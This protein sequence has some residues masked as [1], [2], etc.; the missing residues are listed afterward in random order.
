MNYKLKYVLF[1]MLIFSVSTLFLAKGLTFAICIG[2]GNFTNLNICVSVGLTEV[3]QFFITIWLLFWSTQCACSFAAKNTD[4]PEYHEMKKMLIIYYIIWIILTLIGAILIDNTLVGSH[5]TYMLNYG[6]KQEYSLAV[7]VMRA[8]VLLEVIV[9]I[10]MGY[11]IPYTLKK[12]D[13]Y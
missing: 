7:F 8:N 5:L 6:T 3:L 1:H 10:F 4:V 11:M 13:E 9:A 2:I 12:Y